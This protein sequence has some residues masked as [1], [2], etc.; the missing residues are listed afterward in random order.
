MSA[1]GEASTS[2]TVKC[3]ATD[4][5][6]L[7]TQHEAS[8][9]RVQDLENRASLERVYEE[10]ERIPPRFVVELPLNLGNFNEGAPIHL[11]CQVREKTETKLSG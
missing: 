2:A 4:S 1:F 7:G 3:A 8:W 10:A 5:L 6:L 11:E 9:K